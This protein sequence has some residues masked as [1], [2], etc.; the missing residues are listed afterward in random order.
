MITGLRTTVCGYCGRP[1]AGQN[2]ATKPRLPD[3]RIRDGYRHVLCA[4]NASYGGC[5]V[6]TSTSVASVERAILAYCNDIV[7]L[8]GLFGADRTEGP[9]ARVAAA[10]TRVHEIE[11]QLEKI[12]EAMLASAA[13]GTPMVFARRARELA[14]ALQYVHKALQDAEHEL[15]SVARKDTHGADEVWRALAAGVEA[16]DVDARLRARQLVADTFERM[17]VYARGM[18]P[19]PAAGERDYQIDLILVGRGGNSRALRID[20]K[21]NLVGGYDAPEGLTTTAAGETARSD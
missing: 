3:G 11:A 17:V 10:R 21:G 18:R 19:D 9:R 4:S 8:Q 16:Q 14:N 6:Q 12:T 5:A 7:N 20:R 15:A 2:L 13:G 1:M